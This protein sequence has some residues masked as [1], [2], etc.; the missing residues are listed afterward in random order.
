MI[1]DSFSFCRAMALPHPAGFGHLSQHVIILLRHN[2]DYI[3]KYLPS[4]IRILIDGVISGKIDVF[5]ED[6]FGQYKFQLKN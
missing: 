2:I 1:F 4:H 3:Y 5:N 6:W